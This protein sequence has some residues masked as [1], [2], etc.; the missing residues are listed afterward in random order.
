MA[1]ASADNKKGK[2]KGGTRIK[3]VDS[4]KENLLNAEI[5]L[6]IQGE[7]EKAQEEEGLLRNIGS[8]GAKAL[9]STPD[10]EVGDRAP[11]APTRFSEHPKFLKRSINDLSFTPEPVTRKTPK[12]SE[13]H[14]VSLF[15]QI[16][17]KLDSLSIIVESQSAH[18]KALG[19]RIDELMVSSKGNTQINKANQA[20]VKKNRNHGGPD[21]SDGSFFFFTS[22]FGQHRWKIPRKSKIR[23]S[24]IRHNVKKV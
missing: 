4:D 7:I 23:T 24:S 19:K 8:E 2:K 15:A 12:Y 20:A 10:R 3:P 16:V 13:G 21:N 6:Q 22:L 9:P 14:D 1:S 11:V 17:S 18:I 5:E